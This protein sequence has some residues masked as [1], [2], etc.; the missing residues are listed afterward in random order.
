M[1]DDEQQLSELG[2][3]KAEDRDDHLD[4]EPLDDDDEHDLDLEL[5]DPP[6]D[7]ASEPVGKTEQATIDRGSFAIARSAEGLE[8]VNTLEVLPP[9]ELSI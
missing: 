8:L 9:F 6:D 2:A 4:D 7:E 3:V 1:D 5:H